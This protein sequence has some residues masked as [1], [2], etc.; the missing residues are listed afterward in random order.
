MKQFNIVWVGCHEEG[1]SAFRTILQSGIT[2]SEFITLNDDSFKKRSGGS[3]EYSDLCKEYQIPVGLISTIKNDEAYE[4]IL[5][6]KPDLLIVLGWNEILPERLLDIPTIGTVGAHA[7]MLPH[8][9]GSAPVNWALIKNEKQGGNSLMWLD[10]EVDQGDI[11]DQIGFDITMYDTCKTLYNKVSLTNEVMLIRL[12]DRLQNGL[13]TVMAK[14][15]ETDEPL[16]PR[17]RP[18]DGII[19]WN[20]DSLLIYNFVRAL[21]KPYPG[22]FTFIDGKKYLIWKAS[23]LPDDREYSVCGRITGPVY[24]PYS[25]SCG[26]VVECKKGSIIIHEIEGEDGQLYTGKDLIDLNLK[27]LFNNE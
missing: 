26:I 8:G 27:G 11:I 10:K 18:K 25:E 17:R 15:N 1:V 3:R 19:D 13:P 22:A 7:A 21:A 16:L 6:A 20:A 24:S 12:I 23:L 9:R 5:D 4:M 14:K 2:V